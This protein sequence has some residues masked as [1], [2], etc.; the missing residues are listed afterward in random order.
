[1]EAPAPASALIHSATL[2]S[3]GVFLV[4]RL[5]PLFEVSLYAYYA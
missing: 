5:A 4:L 2:V 3:A 1:M